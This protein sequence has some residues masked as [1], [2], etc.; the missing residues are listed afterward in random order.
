MRAAVSLGDVAVGDAAEA[1]DY[2]TRDILANVALT[3]YGVNDYLRAISKGRL[4]QN[5]EEGVLSRRIEAGLYA[6]QIINGDEP[7]PQVELTDEELAQ[8]VAEGREARQ[9][10]IEA[11]TMLVVSIAKKYAHK[12]P[13]LDAIQ[14]GNEGLIH[15]VHKF[16]Y[17]QG[18]KFSTYATWWIRQHIQ[19]G[20]A[21][22]GRVI[23]IPT[24][25]EERVSVVGRASRELESLGQIPSAEAIVAHNKKIK[26]SDIKLYDEVE[27]QKVVSLNTPIS[28]DKELI[29]LIGEDGR[30]PQPDAIAIVRVQVEL[31]YEA[32]CL[33]SPKDR[34]ILERRYG[35]DG[36]T[37]KKLRE[38]AEEF[39]ITMDAVRQALKRSESFLRRMAQKGEITDPRV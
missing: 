11:N 21:R 22:Q 23:R 31:L 7:Y 3:S 24:H 10:F 37:P 25:A 16:D 26:P 18:F 27:R 33:L 30:N 32:M 20:I 36:G 6:E 12:I 13:L 8:L 4:L 2:G 35:L 15:A 29:E 17:Q 14:E 34:S 28:P 1:D 39:G 5:G 9:E 19:S 38:I